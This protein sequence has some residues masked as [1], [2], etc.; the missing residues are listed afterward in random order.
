MFKYIYYRKC[1]NW[2]SGKHFLWGPPY[3]WA[4]AFFVL[5]LTPVAFLAGAL[6]DSD[7]NWTFILV[8]SSFIVILAIMYLSE[9][10]QKRMKKYTPPERFKRLDSIPLYCLSVPFFFANVSMGLRRKRAIVPLRDRAIQPQWLALQSFVLVNWS[11]HDISRAF[12]IWGIA[13][14]R[15]RG[16]H[17]FGRPLR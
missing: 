14:R 13:R 12:P 1:K 4:N 17:L 10:F 2:E 8:S 5:L 9:R 16:G 11:L 3:G 15:F 6:M 7:N